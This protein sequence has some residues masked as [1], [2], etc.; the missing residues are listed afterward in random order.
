MNVSAGN[1]A[2][3][4]SDDDAE[5]LLLKY[6]VSV[7]FRCLVQMQQLKKMLLVWILV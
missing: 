4:E 2:E 3:A 1:N 6:P 5:E 7:L